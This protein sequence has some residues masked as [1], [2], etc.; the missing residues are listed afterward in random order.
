MSSLKGYIQV[1]TGNG[2]GKTTAAIGLAMRAVGAGKKV[3]IGQFIKSM[4]YSELNALKKMEPDIKIKQYGVGCFIGKSP[5]QEDR[6]AAKNALKEIIKIIHSQKYDIVIMDEINMA[7]Y[8]KL[9]SLEDVISVLDQKPESM[10]LV[11]TGRFAPQEIIDRA[12]LVTEMQEVKHY[13]AVGVE[14]REGIEK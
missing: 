14:A 4:H 8:F 12:D 13:Y 10:E 3:Y 7:L 9:I 11:L 2:K 5:E 1:Y 6:D